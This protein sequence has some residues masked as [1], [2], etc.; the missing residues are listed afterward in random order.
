MDNLF[1]LP[2]SFGEPL[3]LAALAALPL[4][5]W[6]LRV[7][8]P[9][10][11]RTL[12]PP[13]RLL[14]GLEDEEQTPAATPWWLLLL[15]LLA[16]ALL[17]VALADPLLGRSPKLAAA[18]P[19]VLVVDNGW[20]A[21][22]DWDQRQ[23]LMTDLLHSARGR[24]VA[25]IPTAGPAPQG[26]LNEGE[27]ARIAKELK[28]MPWPGD[29]AGAARALGRFKF[30]AQ[31]ALYW[32]TDGLEDGQ[33]NVLRG[34]FRRYGGATAFGP[35][36]TAL[37][38]LP[39]TRDA[40]GFAI[41]AIRADG[42][43]P[44][45]VEAGAIGARGETLAAT[46][47]RFRRG[48]TRASGHIALPME[49]RNA[50]SRLAIAGEDS[51]GAVQLLD[52][53]AAQ[54]SAGIVSE[55]ASSEGQPLL[56]DIYY[57][58][59][60][61]SPYAEIAK[62][63]L[64]Q[65]L[66][67]HVSVLILAD[68][69]RISGDDLG[70]VKDFVSKGGMLIRFAGDHMTGGSDDLVPVHLRVG[71]RYLGSAMAWSSPQ[72]LAPFGPSSP[73]NGLETPSE[74]TVS[75]QVLAEPSAELQ[76]RTWAQL[77]DGT[78]LITAQNVGQGWI[79]L[80]HITA[81]PT[82]SSLPLSGLYVDMLKRLL[83]LSAGTP[84][85]DLAGLTSLPPV[86][87]LDGFGHP[88]PTPGD[89]API[90]ARDFAR[91]RVS[92]QHPPGLYG[93]HEVESALNVMHANDR[94]TP[95]SGAAMQTYGNTHARVL[96]P[97][98][99]AAAMILLLLD[100][101]LSLWLRGFTPRKLR[102][103]GAAAAILLFV[104]HARADDAM[105]MKAALDTRLAYV[106]T[107]LSDVDAISQQGLTGLGLALK[108]RTSY[109]P[110]EPIGVDPEHDD[111][112]L[113]PLLYWP[114]DPREKNLSPRALSKIADFMRNGGTIFFDTRDLTL[115]AVHGASSP[116][117]QTL[118]R[119][120]GGLDFPPLEQ[121]PADHVLAKTFYILRDFPG[122]WTGGQIWVE[123]LPPAPKNGA[124][125][126]RGGDGV[127]PVIIGNNDWASAWAVDASGHFMFTPSPGGELQREMAFRFGINLV[128][129]ALTGNYKT[130]VV[131][132]P[133][134]LQ[135]LGNGQ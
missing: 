103:L 76:G 135:R 40:T 128:M 85:R 66:D 125:P 87:L 22:K 13:L 104:P 6:L 35:T 107:G 101:L 43:A 7:T 60:A 32:L 69:A 54:R 119:L 39:V 10:P 84:A 108:A 28:P 134:L 57:L 126:A 110:Q 30:A 120:T 47:L 63:N 29:R 133:A 96:E 56:S 123:A 62:G 58:D 109:E 106:K 82:W 53:G 98:L 124:P 64:S 3:I 102:W 68:V 121:L 117:E 89:A 16:A 18:G 71:G 15:R 118:R 12:F 113:Y 88:E 42:S 112:S 46:R 50:T 65:L 45:E 77:S 33:S 5:W 115:G 21:A 99:L 27:A 111:L 129:Y 25:I 75:R 11:R 83:A 90:A 97:Y 127:S 59:R 34:A 23:D 37:G 55:N 132:A 78:P 14:R 2:L 31:P 9:L 100:C 41:T 38:L 73:F 4:L 52:R 36:R 72:H 79:V 116:G 26:L 74:V 131:H 51:A 49:V 80:F 93:A 8:P 92:P 86:S 17:I 24:A 105:N 44:L 48:Q 81:S 19:L 114:M 67:K 61:L 95:L 91:T 20:T 130:D 70:K 1:G 122:R 94:L